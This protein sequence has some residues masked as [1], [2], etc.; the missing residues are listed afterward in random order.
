[1]DF[2]VIITNLFLV[3]NLQSVHE[4]SGLMLK[5]HVNDLIVVPIGIVTDRVIV[6][7]LIAEKVDNY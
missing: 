4:I 5:Y 7:A 3:E 6:V 2:L 1:M